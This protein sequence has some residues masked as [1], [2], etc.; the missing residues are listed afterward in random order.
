[1]NFFLFGLLLTPLLLSSR[2]F[3]PYITTKTFFFRLLV[4]IALALYLL[5]ALSDAN[6]RPR[7]NRIS[8]AVVVFLAIVFFTSIVG[9]NFYRS[10]WGNTERGEGIL[11]LLHVAAFFFMLTGMAIDMRFW[12]KFFAFQVLVSFATAIYATM[13][14]AGASF[15]ITADVSRVSALIGNASFYAGYLLINI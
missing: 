13:Q 11:T 15:V 2:F 10:F 8:Y 3:F 14:K 12:E 6:Y 4:E 7:W 9:A 1:M 5:V